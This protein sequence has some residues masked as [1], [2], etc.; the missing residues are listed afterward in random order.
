M[1]WSVRFAALALALAGAVQAGVIVVL[2]VARDLGWLNWLFASAIFALLLVGMLRA[3]RLAWL[4]G[5][6]LG[7]LVGAGLAI[8]VAVPAVRTGVDPLPAALLLAGVALPLL[9]HSLA[10]GHHTAFEWF[11]LV[12]PNC[13]ATTS[14]GDLLMWTARCRRC[15]AGF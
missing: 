10:L 7:F 12:C 14:R 13:G 2:G 1:P 4:W 9:V 11:G 3:S 15:G 5:R 8:A 6:H